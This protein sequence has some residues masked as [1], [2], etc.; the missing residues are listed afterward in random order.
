MPGRSDRDG[1]C[2]SLV[3]LNRYV[4]QL[5]KG[6]VAI[7]REMS[8]KP[9]RTQDSDYFTRQDVRM[10]A[11][12]NGVL[13]WNEE[14]LL[15]FLA[16]STVTNFDVMWMIYWHSMWTMYFEIINALHST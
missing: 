15:G 5:Q 6:L 8:H 16:E 11:H 1:Q 9:K 4:L 10:K 14:H 7:A 13:Y 12:E 3:K 2:D